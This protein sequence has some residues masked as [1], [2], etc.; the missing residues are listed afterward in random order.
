MKTLSLSI[1]FVLSLPTLCHSQRKLNFNQVTFKK[2]E[3]GAFELKQIDP[4]NIGKYVGHNFIKGKDH[5]IDLSVS[6][7]GVGQLIFNGTDKRFTP[8]VRFDLTSK[9]TIDTTLTKF[10]IDFKEETV[11]K[12]TGTIKAKLKDVP[13]DVQLKVINAFTSNL[14]NNIQISGEIHRIRMSES[15]R[16]GIANSEREVSTVDPRFKK[17][18]T[19]IKS[20][21][22]DAAYSLVYEVCI[23]YF[24]YTSTSIDEVTNAAKV[25]FEANAK[26]LEQYHIQASTM[27][28]ITIEYFKS[29]TVNQDGANTF[30]LSYGTYDED[31]FFSQQSQGL[32]TKQ[33][34]NAYEA[35]SNYLRKSTEPLLTKEI[36]K[37]YFKVDENYDV[38][39]NIGILPNLESAYNVSYDIKVNDQIVRTVKVNGISKECQKVVVFD[40]I[41]PITMNGKP[42][43]KVVI[44]NVVFTDSGGK[45]L[46]S[47]YEVLQYSTIDVMP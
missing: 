23:L 4:T 26:S 47:Q 9:D 12:V 41:Q 20:T 45:L 1:L 33:I 29:L 2:K 21:N 32:S 30:L 7:Y 39:F 17:I 15:F 27:I 10:T 8:E 11:K 6:N 36:Q 18:N 13:D 46:D 38:I 37:D 42:T 16:R 34:D 25:A 44:E 19:I 24:S 35:N 43:I 3:M 28:D 31:W 40:G 22:R 14:K 5:I